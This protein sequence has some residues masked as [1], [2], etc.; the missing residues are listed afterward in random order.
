MEQKPLTQ[1]SFSQNW[2]KN[3]LDKYKVK[4]NPRAIRELDCIYEYIASE[5]SVPEDAKG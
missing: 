5:K 2:R 4:V 1:K 3:I